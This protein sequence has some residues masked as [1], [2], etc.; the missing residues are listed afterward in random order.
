MKCALLIYSGTT[1][2]V[3]KIGH[4]VEQTLRGGKLVFVHDVARAVG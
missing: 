2:G 4:G 1:R 3:H